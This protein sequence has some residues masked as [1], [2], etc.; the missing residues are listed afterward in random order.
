MMRTLIIAFAFILAAVAVNAQT[1]P[2][3]GPAVNSNT[4]VFVNSD[5]LLN[6]YEYYKDIKAKLLDLSQ[7]AQAEI[8]AKG[9]AFQK[10]VI[11]YKKKVSSLNLAQR[12][13]KEKALANEQQHL[14]D[15]SQNTAKQLQEEQE[16]Q[17][18]KLYDK[19]ADYLKTYCKTKGY[20]IVLTYSKAN[21]SMLYGD[22]SLDVTK[23]VLA[24]LN[25]AYK[26]EN[27]GK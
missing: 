16:E 26:K 10:E 24:G 7:K 6:N 3:A 18:S 8:A 2:A 20:K 17:N 25:E 12:T 21:P 15:L 4:I 23:D 14:Q 13:A 19:L 1:A 27:P 9:E 11:A 22:D 5:T